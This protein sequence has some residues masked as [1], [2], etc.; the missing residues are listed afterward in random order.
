MIFEQTFTFTSYGELENTNNTNI[1]PV[2]ISST[3][4]SNNFQP[5]IATDEDAER[6]LRR[7]LTYSEMLD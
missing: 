1:I 6:I 3:R 2:R 4:S 5:T 7:I